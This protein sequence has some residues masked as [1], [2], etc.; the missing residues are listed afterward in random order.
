MIFSSFNA[1]AQL[2]HPDAVKYR[3]GFYN[4]YYK[5]PDSAIFYVR[6]LASD[7]QNASFLRQAVHD[8]VFFYFSDEVK[9]K[10]KDA[11]L[12]NNESDWRQK[13]REFLLPIYYT[14]YK[15]ST[16][17]NPLVVNTSKPIFLWVKVHGLQQNVIHN[18]EIEEWD[19]AGAQSL[20]KDKARIQVKSPGNTTDITRI[21]QLVK[22]FVAFQTAQENSF[23]D[24]TGT[25]ALLMYKDIA[26]E[27]TMQRQAQDL[28][29][30]TMKST[31]G[32]IQNI[33]VNTAPDIA[34][35]KR[36][37]NRYLYAAANYFKANTL[38]LAGD[39]Q[40]AGTY[41]K[42]AAEYSPDLTD[43]RKP[44]DIG[45]EVYLFGNKQPEYFQM[46]YV[47][48]LK[49]YGDK[50][51]M[52]SALT[53][54]AL[55]NPVDHKAELA[56][57]FAA[58]FAQRENFNTYWRKAINTGLDKAPSIFIRK[59]DG[60]N[61]SS[62]QNA[63]K[64]ILVDFWGTWCGPCRIE[65]PDLQKLYLKSISDT[66]AGL[67]IITIACQDTKEKVSAYMNE[68]KYTFPVA[69][70]DQ[71]ILSTYNVHGFPTKALITPEGNYLVIPFN[72]DWLAFIDRYTRD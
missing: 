10:F 23:Q 14:L 34:I 2:L 20:V 22:E 37:W 35:A 47:N 8:D 56:A 11:S 26:N 49:K 55:R 44:N 61:Y 46:A 7:H 50:N 40:A 19:R 71:K 70:E 16:D 57:Y 41:Y 27:K 54:M 5:N 25:Y 48:Y 3:N 68:F 58:N 6:K 52:L 30:A 51:Q 39:H 33:N 28:L 4:N 63:G 66:S 45:S 17:A 69:M 38:T 60:S 59:T 43:L 64:W 24:K 53:Q 42:T 29:S 12:K 15:M 62:A 1:S 21:K 32:A 13:Y 31:L 36:A 18:K 9:Q 65:H 67:D 72:S